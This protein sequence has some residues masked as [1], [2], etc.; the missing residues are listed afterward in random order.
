VRAALLRRGVNTSR[1]VIRSYGEEN[2]VASNDTP[3]GRRENR[4]AQVII[5]DMEEHMVGSSTGSTAT[6]SSGAGQSGQDGQR[7]K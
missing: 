3:V 5:G 6:T 2:P 1:I 4:R 7:G